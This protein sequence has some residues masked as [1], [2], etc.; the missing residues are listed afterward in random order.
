MSERRSGTG[1]KVEMEVTG[2]HIA[3]GVIGQS[4][5]GGGGDGV[6]RT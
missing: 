3:V 4:G 5:G 1:G 6:R 2:M